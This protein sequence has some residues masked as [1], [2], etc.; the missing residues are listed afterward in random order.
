MGDTQNVLTP[1]LYRMYLLQEWKNT[2]LVECCLWEKHKEKSS[3]P[4][5]DDSQHDS[6]FFGLD[7]D[8]QH[9]DKL[10]GHDSKSQPGNSAHA[11]EAEV[12]NKH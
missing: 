4:A 2:V 7:S 5:S 8:S 3:T 12:I 10:F 11:W 1:L 6:T 9:D